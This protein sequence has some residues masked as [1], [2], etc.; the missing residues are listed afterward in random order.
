[1]REWRSGNLCNEKFEWIFVRASRWDRVKGEE[2][3]GEIFK[4][5][6]GIR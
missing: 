3:E 4:G 6:G 1:M 2:K 5:E